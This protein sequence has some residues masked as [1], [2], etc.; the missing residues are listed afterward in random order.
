[1]IEVILLRGSDR[2]DF[3]RQSEVQCGRGKKITGTSARR[4]LDR[5]RS[6]CVWLHNFP[7]GPEAI[8]LRRIPSQDS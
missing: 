3:K 1:M 8:A 6:D 5:T 4:F 2:F 7:A